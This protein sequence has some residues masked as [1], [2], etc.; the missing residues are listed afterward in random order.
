MIL[1]VLDLEVVVVEQLMKQRTKTHFVA[2]VVD[3]IVV[4]IK[5]SRK[6]N[7]LFLGR[8]QKSRS[9]EVSKN[10]SRNLNSH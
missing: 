10:I 3:L 7:L 1:S 6:S 2:L 8:I 9:S 5:K 4:S